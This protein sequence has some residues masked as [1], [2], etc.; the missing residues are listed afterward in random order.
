MTFEVVFTPTAVRDLQLAYAW[1]VRNAP[2]TAPAWRERLKSTIGS[3]KS[4]PSRCSLATEN[5]KVAFE[6][7]QLTFGRRRGA[8]RIVFA[9]HEHQV[10][11]LRAQRRPLTRREIEQADDLDG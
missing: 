2:S 10:R 1:A 4:F 8:F 7:R 5:H 11:I 6:I 9:I 3:L